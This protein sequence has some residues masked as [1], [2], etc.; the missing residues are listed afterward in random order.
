MLIVIGL[1]RPQARPSTAIIAISG[2]GL[3]RVPAVELAKYD[4]A[5][6]KRHRR[7]IREA[8]GFRPAT[9]AARRS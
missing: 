2:A 1:S 6:A 4:L 9:L 8:L 5:G 7:Q 3:V